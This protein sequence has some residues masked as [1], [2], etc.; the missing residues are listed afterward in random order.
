MTIKENT[1]PG[2]CRALVV[3]VMGIGNALLGVPL[4]QALSR[5]CEAPVAV[6]AWPPVT[7]RLLEGNPHVGTVV[8]V[9]S[10]SVPGLLN[11]AR[12]CRALRPE[13]T[14]EIFPPSDRGHLLSF[15]SGAGMR[16]GFVKNGGQ[17]WMLNRRLEVKPGLHDVEQNLR[18]AEWPPDPGNL[19]R[20]YLS[21]AELDQAAAELPRDGAIGLHIGSGSTLT[22]RRWPAVSFAQLLDGLFSQ[23]HKQLIVF[24]GPGQEE[25]MRQCRAMCRAAS[26]TTDA[27]QDI[28]QAAAR[29]SRCRLFISNDA[30]WL[31]IAAALEV[32]TLGIYGPTDPARTAPRGPNHRIVKSGLDCAPCYTYERWKECPRGHQCLDDISPRQVIEQALQML[33]ALEERDAF[34]K[35]EDGEK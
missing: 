22:G 5:R 20:I 6:A 30:V 15:L 19:P 7:A 18:L 25:Q 13:E 29:V 26:P 24:G 27:G 28:R 12:R 35:P 34:K 11:A 31:H 21:K 14:W 2:A 33:A 4:I 16:R 1:G 9:E 17:N 23:G 32:P 10:N 3:S 8:P